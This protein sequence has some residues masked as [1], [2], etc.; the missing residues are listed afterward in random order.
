MSGLAFWI[1]LL[2]RKRSASSPISLFRSFASAAS[3]TKCPLRANR[4]RH[5]QIKATA[6]MHSRA[7]N[8]QMYAVGAKR[9]AMPD[10]TL[11]QVSRNSTVRMSRNGPKYFR[12]FGI[13]ASRR[14]GHFRL[15]LSDSEQTGSPGIRHVYA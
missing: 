12:M 1:W 8:T 15:G 7:A 10:R 2:A 3:K 6:S 4:P 11:L 14:L 5:S 9:S 13:D